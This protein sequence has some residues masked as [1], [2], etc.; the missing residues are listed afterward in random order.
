MARVDD[1]LRRGDVAGAFAARDRALELAPELVETR[2]WAA[3]ATASA[4]ES[5]AAAA[6]LGDLLDREPH[7]REAMRRLALSRF[8]PGV[9]AALE[10]ELG[11]A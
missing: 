1:A 4:G 7:W 5:G 10:E 9:L 6:I 3:L 8:P 11:S 2:V